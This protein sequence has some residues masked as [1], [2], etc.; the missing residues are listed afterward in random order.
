MKIEKGAMFVA[1]QNYCQMQK[2]LEMKRERNEERGKN[3]EKKR[4]KRSHSI[5]FNQKNQNQRGKSGMKGEN[6]KNDMKFM[7]IIIK[8]KSNK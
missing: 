3:E 1:R 6:V 2:T 5:T 8:N 7:I 4:G